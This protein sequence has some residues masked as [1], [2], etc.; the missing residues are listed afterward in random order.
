MVVTEQVDAV[1]ALGADPIKKLV[2]PRVYA[3]LMVMPLS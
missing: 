2:A 3:C 1:R